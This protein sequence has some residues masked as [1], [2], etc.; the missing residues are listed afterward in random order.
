M[1][2]L[3]SITVVP[4]LAIDPAT[5]NFCAGVVVPMPTLPVFVLLMFVPFVHCPYAE[6]VFPIN[7]KHAATNA[8]QR[9]ECLKRRADVKL[10]VSSF[11]S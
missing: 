11:L 5:S 10:I 7:R 8:D 6:P 1:F 3:E 9:N 4:L 2:R